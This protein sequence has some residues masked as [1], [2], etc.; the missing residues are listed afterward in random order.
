MNDYSLGLTSS[1]HEKLVSPEAE[2]AASLGK[3]IVEYLQAAQQALDQ[4]PVASARNIRAIGLRTICHVFRLVLHATRNLQLTAH[5]SKKASLYFIEFMAQISSETNQFLRLT[6]LDAVLFTYKKT[7]F[8]IDDAYTFRESAPEGHQWERTELI[9]DLYKVYVGIQLSD[10]TL[11][12]GRVEAFN[13]AVVSL[14]RKSKKRKHIKM[15]R[16]LLAEILTAPDVEDA[17]HVHGMV[18]SSINRASLAE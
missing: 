1:Y 7:I 18:M 16:A 4:V 8:T 14:L 12:E 9:E 11:A 6:S 5:Q 13:T 3:L 10:M 2:I 17:T 15:L